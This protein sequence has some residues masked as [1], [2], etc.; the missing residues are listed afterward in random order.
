MAEMND[1]A[2][3]LRNATAKSLV[4]IDE[5]GRG[6][7]INDGFGIAWSILEELGT[8][9]E[10]TTYCATHY[11]ELSKLSEYDNHSRDVRMKSK[12]CENTN[13]FFCM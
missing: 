11:H 13:P 6:T 7:S 9:N 3:I 1:A 12:K 5:L 8:I 4:L 2:D 10:A